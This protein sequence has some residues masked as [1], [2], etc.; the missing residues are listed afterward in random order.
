M[1]KTNF[2]S[3]IGFSIRSIFINK[4][5]S[6]SIG[7]GMILGAAIFSSI[8]FYGSI[9]NSL[10]VQTIIEN[11][12]AEITFSPYGQNLDKTPQEYAQLIAQEK[13]IE[14]TIVIY[15]TSQ[16]LTKGTT[17]SY[18]STQLVP[19]FFPS[20]NLTE[21]GGDIP[22]SPFIVDSNYIQSPIVQNINLITGE[23]NLSND[24]CI[25]AFTYFKRFGLQIND[26][27]S[28][29]ITIFKQDI[30]D[31]G[32]PPE[33]VDIAKQT[34]NLTIVGFFR[35][36]LF[37]DQ[38]TLV[39]SSEALNSNI[40]GNFTTNQMFTIPSKLDLKQLPLNDLNQLV[41]SINII[42]R[43][44]EQK[45]PLKGYNLISEVL[46]AFQGMVIIMQIIDTVLYLPAIILSIILI[47]IGAELSLQERKF[48]V[49]V[50]KAQGASPK[51][52]RRMILTEV[53]LV[54]LIGETIGIFLGTFGAAMVLSTHRFMVIDFPTVIK[55]YSA[56]QI[57]P[58]SIITTV[59]VTFG[60]LLIASIKKTNQFI[61]QEVVVAK[62]I[63]KEKKGWFKKIYGDI[64]FFLLGLIGVLLTVI[65]NQNPTLSFSFIVQLLQFFT[66]ILLWYGGA[67]VV[68]R[69]S[70]KIP[71]KLD[72][73]LVKIF[74]DIGSLLKGS[75]SRRHQNF[76]RMTVLLCLSVSLV[77]FSA[78]QG[79]TSAAEIQRNADF[80]VGGDLRIDMF[81]KFQTLTAENFTGFEDKIETVIPIYYTVFLVGAT[82][83]ECYGAD[84]SLYGSEALWHKDSIIG[85]SDWNEGLN[86]L[87]EDPLNKVALGRTTA[88]YLEI[89]D[90]PFFELTLLNQSKISLEAAVLVDHAPGKVIDESLTYVFSYKMLVD[91]EFIFHY[92]PI[93]YTITRAIINL[94]PG[95]DSEKENL[96][97]QLTSQFDWIVDGESYKENIEYTQE[98][99]GLRFGFPGLLTINFILALVTAVIGVFI[100]MY[101]IINRRKQEFAVLIA[102]GASKGQIIKLV[103]SEVISMA[104]FAT[105]F[106]TFIGFLLGY[107]FNGFFDNF[108]ITNF[109]RLIVYPPIILTSTII[110]SF[111]VILI[112]TLIPAIIAARTNV[113][114]Q[115]RVV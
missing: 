54:G 59:L 41:E 40:M 55:A 53:F 88:R 50:L 11:V 22:F 82:P 80:T 105:L 74:K 64:I 78:I 28:L 70:L 113:V 86:I 13:E 89:R 71:E 18:Y 2:F 30:P 39:F 56:L 112:A 34:F 92:A 85:Y 76:P 107:Q 75:L 111:L 48:E 52:I 114:E 57:K 20:Y 4:R 21:L 5:R 68:S 87:K 14:D 7:A 79:E 43:R 94:K 25:L 29:N 106:G 102:E 49:S 58:W 44:V 17:S 31:V 12:E 27:I 36:G 95:V 99:E 66:P 108:S 45:Y 72:K 8:F 63:E 46:F 60:I 3:F 115:M 23:T 15:G 47:N 103:L 51:Q 35:E 81:G 24:S 65:E 91:K 69:L 26:T 97:F 73:L 1:K 61:R 96:V 98:R 38:N 32:D 104:I 33:P 6:L 93:S 110:G 109:H 83:I 19:I 37:L 67:S 16:E 90:N 42:L 84:L 100:F 62:T 101:M 77:I 9:M 10:T